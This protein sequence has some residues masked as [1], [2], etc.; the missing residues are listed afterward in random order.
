MNPHLEARPD[1]LPPKTAGDVA[2]LDRVLF[3]GDAPTNLGGS[4]W[5]IIRDKS[6]RGIAFAGMKKCIMK[7]NQGSGIL[8]RAGVL[9]EH[10][11]QGYHKALIACRIKK[12]REVGFKSAIAYVKN[13]N[14]A[15]ANALISQGFRLYTPETFFAG[16]DTF[17]L[18]KNLK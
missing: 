8:T 4:W 1:H 3:E 16:K 12:A 18:R 5:W 17:Y 15:S 7:E 14:L 2:F 9:E 10:R 13:R 6:G 11:G